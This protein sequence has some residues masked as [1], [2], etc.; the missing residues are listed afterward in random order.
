M[1]GRT[2]DRRNGVVLRQ[3]GSFRA[4]FLHL[5]GLERPVLI[6]EEHV[7]TVGLAENNGVVVS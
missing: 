4:D 7:K 2:E 1:I 6:E 5:V 3:D